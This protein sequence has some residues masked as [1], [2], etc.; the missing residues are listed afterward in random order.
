M[1]RSVLI[2]AA[3]IVAG[4]GDSGS[5][6]Y[7]PDANRGGE[8]LDPQSGLD[9][10]VLR[11]SAIGGDHFADSEEGTPELPVTFKF[12][13]PREVAVTSVEGQA[14]I[15]RDGEVLWSSPIEWSDDL[16]QVGTL[17]IPVNLP[18]RDDDP[19]MRAILAASGPREL[20]AEFRLVRIET[21]DGEVRTFGEGR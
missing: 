3:A 21:A 11:G 15:R 8:L 19:G 17:T 12:P 18:Y 4:C 9:A 13:I 16:S 20:E 5:L 1:R 14:T 10:G 2:I 7:E 6:S